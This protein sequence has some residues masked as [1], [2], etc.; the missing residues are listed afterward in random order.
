MNIL[1]YSLLGICL[2]LLGTLSN[3]TLADKRFSCDTLHFL[4]A[5]TQIENMLDRILT[6]AKIRQ[7]F[8]ICRL[9]HSA[10]ASAVIYEKKR[11]IAYDPAFLEGLSHEA[12]ELHWGKVTALAHEIGHHIYRHTDKMKGIQKQPLKKRLAIQRQFELK[13]DQFAGRVLAIMGASLDNTQAIIRLLKVHGNIALSAHPGVDKRVQAVTRGWNIGCRQARSKCNGGKNFNRRPSLSIQSPLGK[14]ATPNYL[15][16]MRQAESLKGKKKVSRNYCNAYANLAVHQTKRSLQYQ[17]GFNVNNTGS[18]WSKAASLQSNW[19]MKASAHAT[20]TEASFRE[21]KLASCIAR[22]KQRPQKNTTH[23]SHSPLGRK[24]TAHFTSLIQHSQRLK[25]V[26]VNRAY[27]NLYASVAVQ[28]TRRNKQHRCGFEVGDRV[29]RWS[30][31]FAP[32]SN[33]CM[34][35]KAAITANE[36]T[37]RE[38]KLASCV[39]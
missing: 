35:V 7:R 21:T 8:H 10:N 15:R 25:G 9:P 13:A 18:P 3:T 36:A 29:N 23:S 2:L 5:D 34:K 30:P 19:C 4:N 27:C 26:R 37:F 24:A 14:N 28:Q 20:S 22:K 12:G 16:F 32:Q 31:S 38:T 33:W 6:I 11:I 39:P 17:C 1:K